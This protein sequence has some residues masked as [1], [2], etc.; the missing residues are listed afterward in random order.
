MCGAVLASSLGVPAA[1]LACASHGDSA[2]SALKA[3]WLKFKSQYRTPH[4]VGVRTPSS[5]ETAPPKLPLSWG[6]SDTSRWRPEAVMANAASAALNQAWSL[7]DVS[8]VSVAMPTQFADSGY[9]PYGDGQSNSK[10]SFNDAW[11]QSRPPVV[12][13]LVK[14]GSGQLKVFFRLDRSIQRDRSAS[15]PSQLEIEVLKNGVTSRIKIPLQADSSGDFTGEWNSIPQENASVLVRPQPSFSDWFP[16]YFYHPV[17][18]AD[19]LIQASP[20]E[21]R[22]FHGAMSQL[23]LVDPQTGKYQDPLGVAKKAVSTGTTPFEALMGLSFPQGYNSTPYMPANIHGEFGPGGVVTGVGKG[24]TWVAEDQ[25]S[26]PFKTMYT[27]FERRN[28]RAEAS[29]RDGGVASGGGWHSIGNRSSAGQDAPVSG[30]AEIIVNSLESGS[31]VVASGMMNV[32]ARTRHAVPSG[33]SIAYG[34][35]DVAVVRWLRPGEGFITEA[36][37]SQPNLHWYFFQQDREV[38]TEEW[39]GQCGS[40]F[41]CQ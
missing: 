38:C 22:K 19:S 8:D 30:A 15:K 35:S 31:L 11:G 29:A 18:T 27:C 13:T 33:E 6:G 26:R 10:V 3:R 25:Q 28:S 39:V 2:S 16:V 24:W 36:G 40:D 20:P 12:A 37:V 17:K 5:S 9:H 21:K 14:F 4:I 7:P 1:V 23:S 34:L 41:A 32:P